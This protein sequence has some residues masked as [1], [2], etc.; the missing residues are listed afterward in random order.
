[1]PENKP[2][3]KPLILNASAIS[4]LKEI[5]DALKPGAEARDPTQKTQLIRAVMQRNALSKNELN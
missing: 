4:G 2:P 1:M 5:V 3:Q